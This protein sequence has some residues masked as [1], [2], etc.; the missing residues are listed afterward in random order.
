EVETIKR[1]F[2]RAV[3]GKKIIGVK[4]NNP[5]VIKSP[6]KESFIKCLKGAKIKNVLRKGKLLI[7]E[8][9]TGKSLL[10]HLK[11]TGQLVYP[12]DDINSRVSFKLS[13]NKLLDY[14]D[15]R[16]LGELR[17][18]D[19]WASFRFIRE[20]GPE[21]FHLTAGKFKEMLA[22]RKTMIKP[23]LMDQKFIA[24]IGN[25]Y[26]AEILFRAGIHPQR[27]SFSLSDK[28]NDKLFKEI[29]A[30]LEEAIQHKGSSIDQYVQLSGTPG[31][32]A[33][34]HKVYGRAGENCFRCKSPI[35]RIALGG[36]GTYFCAKCQ[37]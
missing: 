33:K 14:N 23:L 6:K 20:L 27:P 30:V 19:D 37:K 34:Y 31:D 1:E 5:K 35:K 12:G 3:L 7:F 13:D 8:L 4:I 24:G 17:V 15:S 22:K 9:S 18:I 10:I 26:A 28:E 16:L 29:K 32:Y 21:I 25:L 2:K 36:R 11:L